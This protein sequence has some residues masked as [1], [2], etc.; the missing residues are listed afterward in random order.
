MLQAGKP[1]D[2]LM[3]PRE[4]FYEASLAEGARLLPCDHLAECATHFRSDTVI[5]PCPSKGLV[6]RPH[7]EV[8]CPD[9]SEI[10][11]QHLGRR[12]LEISAAGGHSLLMIGPPG[13]GKTMLA[14]RLPGILPDMSE[15]E[16]LDSAVC[17]AIAVG[18]PR[19][20]R[21]RWEPWLD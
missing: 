2:F 12:A 14:E 7:P 9:L 10:S 4:N 18:R 21:I 17:R 5:D 19:L 15:T 3:L 8:H 6:A 20:A 11:G 16:A 13:C 1:N